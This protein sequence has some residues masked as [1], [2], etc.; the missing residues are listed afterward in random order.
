M[1]LRRLSIKQRLIAN[2]VILI[3][4]LLLILGLNQY[5]T[6]EQRQLSTAQHLNE[7]LKAD[8][9]MLRRNE[10]DFLMRSEPRYLTAFETNAASLRTNLQSLNDIVEQQHINTAT[11]QAFRQNIEQYQ[12]GFKQVVSATEALGASTN[13]GLLAYIVQAAAQAQQRVPVDIQ[14]VLSRLDGLTKEFLLSKEMAAVQQFNALIEQTAAQQQGDARAALSDYQT[15]F[16]RYVSQQQR[17]GLDENSGLLS[18]MRDAVHATEANLEELSTLVSSA[19]TDS[20]RSTARLMLI[21]FVAILVLVVMVNLSI[22]RSIIGPVVDIEARIHAIAR[23]KD[24]SVRLD[25]HGSDEVA[26]MANSFNQMMSTFETLIRNMATAA[27]Q[28]AAASHEL[29]TVSDEVS[30]IAHDQEEQTTM[31]ATAI[32]E[33]A[34]AIQEVA[35]NALAASEAADKGATEANAGQ[36]SIAQ[37]IASMQ[38][39][40]ATGTGASERLQVL[41][42][43]INEI[44]KVVDVIQAIA[45]QTNLLALNAAIEAARAGEHGRGFAVVA[46]EVRN[47]AANTKSSTE[48]IH[49]TTERLLRGAREAIEAMQV[50][51]QQA[52]ESA[53]LAEQAGGSFTRVYGSIQQVTEMGIQIST[54]T[55]EQSSVAQDITENVNRVADSVRQV[56][57]GAHQCAMSS[58]EL[59]RLAS[60]FQDEVTQFKVS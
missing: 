53:Q 49:T 45:E 1:N 43:R 2:T 35:G 42:D 11:L 17:L 57:T 46:D 10:K 28:L 32:T 12:Q 26:A 40:Q 50:S 14:L 24:L 56:V 23:D 30:G 59:A 7:Q 6:A 48:T 25:T 41:N 54:A 8:M 52:S 34:A 36:H 31:I 19:L 60:R 9:L 47:L 27:D 38:Q 29:S 33:M 51:S 37:N 20:A 21:A 5:Q 18:E 3:L 16:A 13:T 22:S 39:L 55:E 58:Q 15:A 44:S 4:G